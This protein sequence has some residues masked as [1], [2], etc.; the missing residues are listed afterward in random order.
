LA[1]DSDRERLLETLSEAC[2]KTGWQVHAYWE[3]SVAG[4]RVF[5]E[6]M[7][8]RRREDLRGEFKRVERRW[9]LGGEQFRQELLEQVETRPQQA[10]P[11]CWGR[12]H[13]AP[14]R[15]R[16]ARYSNKMRGG[17]QYGLPPELAVRCASAKADAASR[18]RSFHP[19]C[20]PTTLRF[21][22]TVRN[23]ATMAC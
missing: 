23:S 1:D 20:P 15:G 2:Q 16:E 14:W 3:D 5:G 6:R 10:A 18:L 9:C 19:H 4:R 7:E 22:N 21:A 8:W 17:R 13:P 11:P 12:P